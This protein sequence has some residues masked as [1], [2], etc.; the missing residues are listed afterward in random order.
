MS[1]KSNPEKPE[2]P[3]HP[4]CYVCEKPIRENAL[5]IGQGL[6]RHPSKC[7][8]GGKVYMSVP[9]LRKKMLKSIGCKS[10][11]QY[12]KLKAKNKRKSMKEKGE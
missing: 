9:K 1:K 3:E 6:Y 11:S 7:T 10:L 4:I 2:R 8:P 5:Y 12:K